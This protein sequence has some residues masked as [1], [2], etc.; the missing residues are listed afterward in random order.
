MLQSG[1][2]TFDA[3]YEP[4]SGLGISDHYL[5]D[6][7]RDM[8]LWEKSIEQKQVLDENLEEKERIYSWR[9]TDKQT[10]A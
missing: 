3:L 4:I 6:V 2:K 7:L 1:G 9:Q 10:S 5:S 8:L